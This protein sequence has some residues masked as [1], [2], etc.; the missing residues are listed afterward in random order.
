MN[1]QTD[2]KGT[3]RANVELVK[4]V[5]RELAGLSRTELARVLC[6]RLNLRD[7]R[8]QLQQASCLKAMRELAG[9]GLFL[10]PAPRRL[11]AARSVLRLD[12]AV[13]APKAVPQQVEQVCGLH[14]QLVESE[15][16]RRAWNE[17]MVREHPYGGNPLV[18]RQVRYLVASDHGFLG[19]VGLASAALHLRQRERWIGWDEQ[20]RRTHLDRIVGLA[21][22]LIR[23]SVR[24][25]NLASHVLRMTVQS[26]PDDFERLYGYRPW[27]LETFVQADHNG[28]SHRAADWL[29]IGSTRGRGRQDSSAQAGLA[30]K[31][32]FV[33]VLDPAFRNHMGITVPEMALPLEPAQGL[34]SANW[35]ANELGQAELGD[36]R[37]TRRLVSIAG[38][39]GASPGSA[40]CELITGDRAAASG[41]Y[42]FI[43]RPDPAQA[44]MNGILAS[45]RERT[46]RRMQAQR[47]VL[48][49]HDTTDLNFST[50]STCQGLGVIGKNQ[51][52]NETAGLRLHTSMVV[53][54]SDGVPLGILGWQCDA[55]SLKSASAGPDARLIPAQEKETWRWIQG[56]TACMQAGQDLKQT[57][58]IHV[59]DREADF[60][61]LFHHWRQYQSPRDELIIRAKHN[62]NGP[63]DIKIFDHVAQLEPRGEVE[64][65]IPRK[66]AR[67]KK[68]KRTAQPVRPAR[69]AILKLRWSQIT[70]QPPAYGLAHSHPPVNVWLLHAREDATAAS[71]DKPLEWF[72]LSTTA[73]ENP[74][75]AIQ[76]LGWYA[77]RWRIEDWHRILK[78]CC[79][80]E[81]NCLRDAEFLKRILAINMVVAWRVHLMTLLGRE[82]PD[83]PMETLFSDL[84]I[85]VLKLVAKRESLSTPGRLADAI[86]IVARLG[87][88]YNR[89]SDPPPGAQ[90][91]SRGIVRLMALC[92]GVELVQPD[93][94]SRDNYG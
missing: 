27:L 34:G 64:I 63:G 78:T 13:P 74:Q 70:L 77:K 47:E 62:R 20:L 48:C 6:D 29:W 79:R 75:T 55:P 36:R 33:Y 42:R 24:C 38:Q 9:E 54:A 86:G 3:L 32:I 19:A 7:R 40:F 94:L 51:G 18:G 37:L 81:Q 90:I 50:L 14:L 58:V 61:E 22:L 88:Y 92:D 44:D 35:A 53:E 28:A 41:Y 26:V 30:R 89:P 93:Y 91:L 87:G 80:A 49:I 66:S 56:L 23:P 68:G 39:K 85:K 82:V 43:E 1:G 76:I 4:V 73:I 60:F 65:L 2:V 71:A 15:E 83:L 52:G 59:M 8:G 31:D 46:V 12:E 25:A 45:H 10:I 67:A 84:E 69:T 57:R 11:A 72:L 5:A 16:Q 17:L 21:R